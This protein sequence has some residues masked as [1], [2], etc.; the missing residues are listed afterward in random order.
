MNVRS[1]DIQLEQAG[2]QAA[3][4]TGDMFAFTLVN[5]FSAQCGILRFYQFPVVLI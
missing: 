2:S 5:M 4:D 3:R 1:N